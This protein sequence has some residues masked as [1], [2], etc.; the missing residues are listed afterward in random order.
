M[1][2][3][4]LDAAVKQ[5]HLT[6]D[7]ADEILKRLPDMIDHLGERGPGAGPRGFGP[8]PG[9]PEGFGPSPAGSRRPPCSSSGYIASELRR[10]RGRTF[11]T[12]LGLGVGVGLVVTVAALSDGLDKAQD[13]VLEP[14]TGVGTDLSVTRPLQIDQDAG[15]GGRPVRA[16]RSATCPTPSGAGSSARTARCARTF[17]TSASPGRSSRDTNFASGPQLSFA[18]TRTAKVAAT[19]RRE[20]RRRRTHAQP[21]DGVR[22]GARGRPCS[23]ASDPGGGGGA[24]PG[25]PR[26]ST[27][28]RAA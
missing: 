11:L 24:A 3:K 19:G 7:E 18:E 22:H 6:R 9:D 21:R 28:T 27:S 25:R 13:E 20:R 26:A 10:R 17:A 8:P 14:L 4:R 1:L 5:G 12:A 2:S 23:R 15:G 16:S